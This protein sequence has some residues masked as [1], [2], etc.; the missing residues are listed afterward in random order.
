METNM[1]RRSFL[2][3]AALAGA[4]LAGSATLAGC[5][6]K[7]KAQDT[8][9]AQ[10]AEGE[11]KGLTAEAASGQWAF[12][13]SPAPIGEGDIAE[14]VEA[15]VVVVG[16]GTSG[17]ITAVSAA[18]E[19]LNVVVVSA[20]EKPV[21]RGGSNNA[22]FCKAMERKGM[23]RLTPFMFQKEI[24]YAGNQV[25][26]R[27]WYKHYNNSE[28]AMNWVIDIM[29]SAGYKVKVEVGTPLE[30]TDMY[31]ETCSI[32][33]DLGDGMEPDPNM[34]LATGM[35]QPL[36]VGE[37]A[38]KLT[39][40]LGGTI[41]FK[42]KGE[43]LVREEDGKGRVSAVVCSREDGTYAKYVGAKAVVL[44]TGDFSANRDMMYKYAPSYAPYIADE[45][46]DGETNYDAGFQYGG[47][48]KGDGQRMGLWAGA[49]WQKVFPNCVMGGFF[50]PGPRNLYSN[51]LGLLV[52]TNG[53]RFMNEN[54]LSP[55]AGMNNFGQPGKTVF[56]LWN[57]DYARKE[58]VSGSW[59]NDSMHEGDDE[60]IQ[61]A[62]IESWEKD[63]EA[64]VMVKGDTMEEVI[65]KLGLPKETIDT[66]NRYN[67]LCA[68]GE[69]TDYYKPAKLLRSL[70]EGPFY[71]QSSG[72]MLIFLT[73]LGGL[74]TD[75]NMRVCDAE[76]KPLP[77]LYNVGTMVG[78][79][80]ATNY[81]FMIEG[82]N[83]GANCITF[84][85]LTG[86]F[87]AENE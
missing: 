7:P 25:D 68:A 31:Y 63:V 40:E 62:V 69:D 18:E 8:P 15:D 6:A 2:K 27:K 50:G 42:N 33:W 46:Y 83:Y 43:Q 1:N 79:M 73:V 44:A 81:T 39:E 65:E 51:F 17:L 34:T 47:L 86:K 12:E 32:G 70:E 87:I 37:L 84:G 80:F 74:N 29:E 21:A 85:Y 55:C 28:T 9:K 26:E 30:P 49:S 71:G 10:A 64:G 23:D 78:D 58:K 19:G 11:Q 66:V 82:A 38:R 13:M 48:F 20:S 67:E 45:V 77:G 59:N 4:T 76:D 36:L 61:K 72:G 14:T 52:N 75:A 35:M 22:V 57:E 54:C 3:G 53:E 24:F 60:A 41:Y 16:A 56:A 5:A